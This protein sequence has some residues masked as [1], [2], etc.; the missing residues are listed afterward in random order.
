MQITVHR[1][2]PGRA[3][4]LETNGGTSDEPATFRVRFDPAA[5]SPVEAVI[6]TVATIHNV[7]QD[8][9]DPLARVVDPEALETLL[10]VGADGTV[11]RIE[12]VYEGLVVTVRSD[13]WVLLR[14]A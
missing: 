11:D 6:E 10:E 12:F 9:L 5:E 13:G 8:E 1:R 7:D 3:D 14:W 2:A 4:G